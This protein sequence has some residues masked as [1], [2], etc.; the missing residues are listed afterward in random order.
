MVR[1]TGGADSLWA[2]AAEAN[3]QKE[4]IS[5][6]ERR[7]ARVFMAGKALRIRVSGC[8][9]TKWRSID[10]LNR[11]GTGRVMV[12]SKVLSKRGRAVGEL[13]CLF[14]FSERIRIAIDLKWAGLQP[15]PS[16]P[17]CRNRSP[18]SFSNISR[19]ASAR[20]P[21]GSGAGIVP[22]HLPTAMF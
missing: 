10:S 9:R 13:Y 17:S 5:K 1:V 20:L 18:N 3:A 22:R 12:L 7:R 2:A 8:R 4:Q 11:A 14:S 19:R 16:H 21:T 15:L 6:R